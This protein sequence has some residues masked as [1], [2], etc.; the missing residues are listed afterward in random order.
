MSYVFLCFGISMDISH[1][2]SAMLIVLLIQLT[3]FFSGF[4]NHKPEELLPIVGNSFEEQVTSVIREVLQP[5][6]FS[7]ESWSR[8]PYLCEG[9]LRQSYY[10]LDDAVFILKATDGNNSN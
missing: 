1:N 9:D 4:K 5:S 6:G 3:F 10:W 7:V 2:A 8:V